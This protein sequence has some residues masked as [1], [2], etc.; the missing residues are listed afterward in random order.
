M[1]ESDLKQEE[2][3]GEQASTT[4]GGSYRQLISNIYAILAY[5]DQLL[6]QSSEKLSSDE[7]WSIE[8]ILSTIEKGLRTWR[9]SS[10]R[11][12]KPMRFVYQ[13][14]GDAEEFFLPYIWQTIRKS[15]CDVIFSSTKFVIN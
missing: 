8:T 11:T 15:D 1:V 13:E 6:S 10:V 5:F 4:S 3:E 12:I 2:G 7:Q 9:Q 14:D